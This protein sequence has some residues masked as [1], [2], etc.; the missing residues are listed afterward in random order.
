MSGI[1]ISYGVGWGTGLKEAA[2]GAKKVSDKLSDYSD[3]LNDDV[4][5]KLNN[6][7]GERTEDF[8]TALN[9]IREKI[10]QLDD[11]ADKYT[12]Y[13]A[14]IDDLQQTCRAVDKDVAARVESLTGEFKTRNDITTNK[15]F[16]SINLLLT[17]V[18]NST[19][20]GRWLDDAVDWYNDCEDYLKECIEDWYQFQGGKEFVK[21]MTVAALELV[22]AVTGIVATVAGIMA[23]GWTIAA[24][25]ALIGGA[26]ATVNAVTN[27]INEGRA[28]AGY[29]EDPARAQRIS[30]ENSIQDTLRNETHKNISMWDGIAGTLDAV[31]IVCAAVAF[32]D[33]I[34]TCVT[35]WGGSNGMGSA[36]RNGAANAWNETKNAF[37][38][39]DFTN[40][41]TALQSNLSTT[42]QRNFLDVSDVEKGAKSVKNWGSLSKNI[43][44]NINAIADGDFN[45]GNAWSAIKDITSMF[46]MG[47]YVNGSGDTKYVSAFDTIKIP[48]DLYSIG[49]STIQLFTSPTKSSINISIPK[50]IMPD[51][52][53][54][55]R[56]DIPDMKIDCSGLCS[57]LSYA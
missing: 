36:I 43:F 46:T 14:D 25:A 1:V 51:I 18:K 35:N 17:K 24:V 21:G 23:G 22:I 2:D 30:K 8:N 12:T 11:D 19:F 7:A 41:R 20:I 48:G 38:I 53:V 55:V 44:T 40:I 32:V 26:I 9:S 10:A 27:M 33:G 52:K 39:K 31:Q 5:K 42:F 15:F 4:Y 29:G 28:L 6:Y 16:D 56:I 3:A 34:K 57:T 54:D 49:K 13:S 47:D 37:R 50:N 45:K